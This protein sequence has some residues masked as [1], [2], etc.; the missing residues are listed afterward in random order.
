MCVC[1][2][3]VLIIKIV[4]SGQS[5]AIAR[6]QPVLSGNDLLSEKKDLLNP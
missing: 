1:V 2:C 3:I 4:S 6:A 5:D